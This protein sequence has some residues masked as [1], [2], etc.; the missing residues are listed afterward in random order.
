MIGEQVQTA[1][2][3]SVGEVLRISC[4]PESAR[5]VKAS[6]H[7]LFLEWPW[8]R[9]DRDAGRVR[10]NGTSAFPRDPGHWEWHNT[11][12]RLEPEAGEL[13]VGQACLV[14]IKPVEVRVTQ[15][16]RHDPPLAIGWQPRPELVLGVVFLGEEDL[17]EAG[18]A[19][20]LPSAE[21]IVIEC[22][23]S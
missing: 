17:E 6:P 23:G 22:V 10:W 5:V 16:R 11:A 20:Y 12:W 13:E 14:G 1:G 3:Y 21:P 4:A 9:I 19:I 15:I 7:Y 18:F 8:R 2:G